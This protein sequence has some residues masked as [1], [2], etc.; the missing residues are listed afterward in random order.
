MTSSETIRA[1]SRAASTLVWDP[2]VRF[3]HWALVAA[4]AVAYLSAEE[5]AGGPDAL[6]VWGGYVVGVLVVLRVVWGF[7]GPRHARFSDFVRSPI[8][9]AALKGYVRRSSTSVI[10]SGTKSLLTL[11][12]SGMDSNFRSRADR[13]SIE[14]IPTA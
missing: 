9:T 13:S 14:T 6:H 12:W 4:F 1:T 2:L 5:E 10:S 3:G 11:R 7:V 8:G